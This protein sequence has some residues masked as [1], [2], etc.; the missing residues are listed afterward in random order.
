MVDLDDTMTDLLP[1]WVDMLNKRYALCTNWQAISEWDISKFFPMLTKE[2]IFGVLQEP[3]IWCN[4]KPKPYAAE[5]LRKLQEQGLDV[6]ICTATYY[7]NVAW[8]F[9]YIIERYFPFID[10]NHMIIASNKHLVRCDYFID[11]APHNLIGASGS[12]FI[13]TAPH[14]KGF[15]AEGNGIIRVNSW[16]EILPYFLSVDDLIDNNIL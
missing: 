4:V 7:K 12:R 11:D 8:K 6:Y 2:Q 1:V 16:K 3:D 5:V 10:W 15:D 13:M 14:N 9:K